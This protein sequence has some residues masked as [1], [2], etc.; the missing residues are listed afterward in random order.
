MKVSTA[1]GGIARGALWISA[2]TL[3][4][5]V[6]AALR[7]A[8]LTRAFP[9]EGALDPLFVALLPV[10]TLVGVIGLALGTALVPIYARAR[11]RAGQVAAAHLSNTTT[12]AATAMALLVS[13]GLWLVAGPFTGLVGTSLDPAQRMLC[14]RLLIGMLPYLALSVVGTVLAA[15]LHAERRFAWPTALSALPL[16][17]TLLALLLSLR[18]P[19]LTAYVLGMNLGAVAQVALLWLLCLLRRERGARWG[20]SEAGSLRRI[21]EQFVPLALNGLTTSSIAFVDQAMAAAWARGGISSLA[22]GVKPVAVF[23]HLVANS[24]GT[25]STTYFSNLLAQG[26]R[27]S[28]RRTTAELCSVAAWLGIPLTLAIMVVARPLIVL[29]YGGEF[30]STQVGRD[31]VL[32][33]VFYAPRVVLVPAGM[34]G[35]R[36]LSAALHNR[37]LLGVSVGK[38]VL[39]VLSNLVALRLFGVP[40]VALSTVVVDAMSLAIMVL[41]LLRFGFLPSAKESWR[42]FRSTPTR[43]YDRVRQ[44]RPS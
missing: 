38:L 36:V 4:N 35:A 3:G 19:H 41:L 40:G 37:L 1:L 26:D 39:D 43:L 27:G 9:H 18:R 28:L 8:V 16:G 32:V 15:E 11:A 14:E 29:L 5:K 22:L 2:W 33:L 25:A 34:V 23:L 42:V 6:L 10:N 44:S 13:V 7:D 21:W 30:A 17:A 20:W 24:L 31:C 12:A